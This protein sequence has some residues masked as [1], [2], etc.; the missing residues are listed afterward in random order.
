MI[1]VRQSTVRISDCVNGAMSWCS[2]SEPSRYELSNVHMNLSM[3]TK[4]QDAAGRVAQRD[5]ALAEE[6]R[7]IV[8]V[9]D[10][11]Y[12]SNALTNTG[13]SAAEV[14][15]TAEIHDTY[16]DN[17]QHIVRRGIA[18]GETELFPVP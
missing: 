18:P 2:S 3:A 12:L 11:E 13:K 5:L 8:R 6:L 16:H 17:G 10:D 1:F 4:L 9:I 14:A 7:E 15:V